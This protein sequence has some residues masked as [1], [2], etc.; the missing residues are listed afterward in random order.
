L[1]SAHARSALNFDVNQPEP[2]DL[3]KLAKNLGFSVSRPEWIDRLRD[4]GILPLL[5]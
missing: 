3:R 5:E 1:Q 4:E 2:V